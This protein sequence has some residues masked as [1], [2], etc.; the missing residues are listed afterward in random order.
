[1]FH[2]GSEIGVPKHESFYLI[3]GDFQPQKRQYLQKKISVEA[4]DEPGMPVLNAYV[5]METTLDP[6]KMQEKLA[7]LERY[8]TFL[9]IRKSKEFSEPILID[10]IIRFVGVACTKNVTREIQGVLNDFKAQLPL[11][12]SLWKLGRFFGMVVDSYMDDYFRKQIDQ[13][14]SLK[15]FKEDMENG[16]I[17]MD[18]QKV[19]ESRV[20]QA[21]AIAVMRHEEAVLRRLEALARI[22]VA[23]NMKEEAIA[24]RRKMMMEEQATIAKAKDDEALRKS[25]VYSENQLIEERKNSKKLQADRERM[26]RIVND[27]ELKRIHKST[28]RAQE[29]INKT[30][31]RIEPGMITDQRNSL[32][33]SLIWIFIAGFIL[34]EIQFL[35]F[36]YS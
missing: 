34:L 4:L 18:E 32:Q 23:E 24:S 14:N 6:S 16:A 27:A 10:Q 25:I 35:Y 28:N 21:E 17:R 13:F 7:Q 26:N 11:L 15:Q 3:P 1:L 30:T 22:E 20:K 5:L 9:L 31:T 19:N 36:F 29:Q 33:P 8:L 12:V 2:V